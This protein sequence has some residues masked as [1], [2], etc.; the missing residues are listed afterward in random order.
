MKNSNKTYYTKDGVKVRKEQDFRLKP[1][2]IH[3]QHQPITTAIGHSP[4]RYNEAFPKDVLVK[5][6]KKKNLY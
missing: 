6:L 5:R 1:N 4:D 3:P 2:H